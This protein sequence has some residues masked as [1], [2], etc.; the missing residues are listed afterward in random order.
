MFPITGGLLV[1]KFDVEG[2]SNGNI[3][4]PRWSPNGRGLQYLLDKNGATNIW[5]Q[6]LTGGPPHQLTKFTTGRIFD[7]R[8]TADGKHL[9][10]SLGDV[11]SDVVLLS[12]LR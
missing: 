7:F 4:G 2:D 8:W 5:E 9:L 1:K 11:T 6:P 10:L 12:N 3:H